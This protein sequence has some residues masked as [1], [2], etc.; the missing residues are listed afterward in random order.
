MEYPASAIRQKE[1]KK[2]KLYVLEN[3]KLSLFVNEMIV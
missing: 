2:E 1:E 3:L